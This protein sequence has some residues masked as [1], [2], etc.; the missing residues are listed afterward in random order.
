[1]PRRQGLRNLMDTTLEE[2]L[3]KKSCVI[4]VAD[5][6]KDTN[7]GS[8]IIV[9]IHRLRNDPASKYLVKN[10]CTY[11]RVQKECM[12]MNSL[13]AARLGRDPKLIEDYQEFFKGEYQ[14][15]V[16]SVKDH[17]NSTIVFSGKEPDTQQIYLVQTADGLYKVLTSPK[18]LF[19]YD[20]FCT[21]CFG[22]EYKS[23]RH[24]CKLICDKCHGDVQH[25]GNIFQHCTDCL[26]SF[27]SEACM[28]EHKHN[29]NCNKCTY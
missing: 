13:A 22:F 20:F 29:G 14:F 18:A 25:K 19:G 4:S 8:A 12:T 27:Y 15:V 28:A 16:W 3:H 2:F 5:S 23:T 11:N 10:Q 6:N 24:H 1:M 7:C 21:K 26:R 9:A 17:A